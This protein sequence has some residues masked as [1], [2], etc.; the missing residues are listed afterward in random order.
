MALVVGENGVGRPA[1]AVFLSRAGYD[2]VDSAYEARWF[3][4]G[5]A[6]FS[7]AI[8]GWFA[9][10][11]GNCR[12]V[13]LGGEDE[14]LD[15]LTSG[16][17]EMVDIPDVDVV[18]YPGLADVARTASGEIDP[19]LWAAAQ[20]LIVAACEQANDRIAVLDPPPGLTVREVHAWRTDV[21]AVDSRHA[22]LYYP[23]L[24]A[25][26]DA[27]IPPCGHVAGAWSRVTRSSGVTGSLG[28]VE[29]IDV[30]D[31]EVDV[32][33]TEQDYLTPIGVNPLRPTPSWGIRTR[34]SRTLSADPSLIHLSTA[35]LVAALTP[36]LSRLLDGFDGTR[37]LGAAVADEV[38]VLS[39]LPDEA[40]AVRHQF[41]ADL[42]VRVEIDLT[43]QLT[44]GHPLTLFTEHPSK[45]TGSA[46]PQDSPPPDPPG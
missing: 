40:F 45:T 3:S 42:A 41:T 14:L 38:R 21:L 29:L 12:I 32:T 26:T 43:G 10:G 22:A 44:R 16:L 7:Q 19:R 35:R 23:W 31:V 15:A 39:G 4:G 6:L 11:G 25:G 1:R 36:A 28:D 34:G 33:T 8:E 9:N 17:R 30:V 46:P 13:P 20:T 37:D 2:D 24:R 5:G 18:C 27:W